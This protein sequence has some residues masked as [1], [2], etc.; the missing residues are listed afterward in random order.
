MRRT[1]D[2]RQE[3]GI[4]SAKELTSGNKIS[5]Y[6]HLVGMEER[7]LISGRQNLWG[8]RRGR[9]KIKWN[10]AIEGILR[11]KVENCKITIENIKCN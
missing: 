7:Q 9:P 2:I 6:G 1:E 4:K 5:W 8:N 3:V 11:E 10:S